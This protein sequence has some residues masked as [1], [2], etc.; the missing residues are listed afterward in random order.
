MNNF[1]LWLQERSAPIAVAIGILVFGTVIVIAVNKTSSLG[2]SATVVRCT[3]AEMIDYSLRAGGTGS[4][5]NGPRCIIKLQDGTQES[6]SDGCSRLM[7]SYRGRVEVLE[8]VT[9]IHTHFYSLVPHCP[10]DA[11]PT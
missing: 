4:A 10:D 6:I 7:Q 3:S 11:P 8:K 9:T 5:A 2:A 1:Y